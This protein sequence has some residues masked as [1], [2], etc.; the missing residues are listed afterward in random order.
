[1]SVQVNE[2]PILMSG[3]MVRALFA[4]T[5]TQT[6]RIVKAASGKQSE[7]LTPELLNKSPLVQLIYKVGKWLD[8]A[9]GAQVT[10]P[11]GGPLTWVAC[12][13]GQPGERLWVRET[14]GVDARLNGVPPRNLF[15]VEGGDPVYYKADGQQPER[16][17]TWRPSIHMPR[18]ASRILLEIVTVRVE[19]LQDITEGDAR[20]EGYGGYQDFYS[21]LSEEDQTGFGLMEEDVDDYAR[22]K[23]FT[24]PQE[25][26]HMLWDKINGTNAWHDNPWV[27]VV[28]FKQVSEAKKG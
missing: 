13:Y 24:Y 26:Y 14:W 9:L 8:S 4:G 2:K 23:G 17:D 19:R 27:W 10:H 1:M 5:K 6:R 28:E 12:P 21:L 15:T 3:P 22:R 7:F 11:N 16:L 25:W 20:A 18:A